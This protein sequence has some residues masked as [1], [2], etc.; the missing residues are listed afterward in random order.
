MAG[1]PSREGVKAPL[2]VKRRK[3]QTEGSEYGAFIRRV[4]RAYSRRV[5]AG[6]VETLRDLAALADHVDQA[7]TEAVAGLRDQG[8]SWSEI[9]ARL[10]VSK[11]AAQQRW[12]ARERETS[13]TET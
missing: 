9:G 3:R 4:L 10:G 13:G 1:P 2:T 12:A 7:I 11:Q 8:Y 6:D 5:A